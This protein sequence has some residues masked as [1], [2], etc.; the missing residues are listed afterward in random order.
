MA[1]NYHALELF[2][3]IGKMVMSCHFFACVWALQ[4]GFSDSKLSTWM[5]EKDCE[6]GLAAGLVTS[7]ATAATAEYYP[8]FN[9]PSPPLLHHRRLLPLRRTWLAAMRGVRAGRAVGRPSVR[10]RVGWD[11][12]RRIALLVMRHLAL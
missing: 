10:V 11:A 2:L 4:T 3:L 9:I 1:I 6:C 8:C 12:L 5:G 7:A